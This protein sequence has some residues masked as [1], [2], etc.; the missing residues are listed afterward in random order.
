M[1]KKIG[2]IEQEMKKTV[3]LNTQQTKQK[4]QNK[5][6]GKKSADSLPKNNDAVFAAKPE[7]NRGA[8]TSR[9]PS[10]PHAHVTA[11][12][13]EAFYTTKKSWHEDMRE[14]GATEFEETKTR[15]IAKKPNGDILGAWSVSDEHGITGLG[16]NVQANENTIVK[17]DGA[18]A[19]TAGGAGDPGAVQNPS[20]NYSAQLYQRK[21]LK[22]FKTPMVRRKKPV[23]ESILKPISKLKEKFERILEEVNNPYESTIFI[24]RHGKTALDAIHRSDGWLD[25]P[26]SDEGRIGLVKAQQYLKDIPLAAI[27]APTLKRTTETAQ[28]IQSGCISDPVIISADQSKTWNLGTLMGTTK[29]PNR[30]I[31]THFMENPHEKPNG[32]ESLDEFRARF[33]PWIAE[34]EAEVS[35][36]KQPILLIMSGSNLRELSTQLY[37]DK[38]VLDMDEGGLLTLKKSDLSWQGRVI[39]GHK[40]EED[41][42]LS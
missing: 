8:G 1:F 34:R 40:D 35:E 19:V 5:L 32:G 37:G 6:D 38:E 13:N 21:K 17:E 29:K 33:L 26:L 12:T 10:V 31:V 18:V 30:P 11:P 7:P 23:G 27:Y 20:S 9:K 2:I 42:W 39:F 41:E 24:M 14:H 25:F 16:T 36:H 4:L 22:S 3:D 15:I 28:I